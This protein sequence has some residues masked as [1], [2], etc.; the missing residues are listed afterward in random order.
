M[1]ILQFKK[2]DLDEGHVSSQ[3]LEFIG[4]YHAFQDNDEPN[5]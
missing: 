1:E 2:I 3:D 5:R 4:S